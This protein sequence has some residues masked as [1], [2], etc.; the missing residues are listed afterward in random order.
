MVYTTASAC[1][2]TR[3]GG[4]SQADDIRREVLHYKSDHPEAAAAVEAILAQ[5]LKD[6]RTYLINTNHTK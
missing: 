1:L 3:Y 5:Y 2:P 6:A 4:V